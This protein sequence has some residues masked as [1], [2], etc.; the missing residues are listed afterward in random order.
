MPDRSRGSGPDGRGRDGLS[1]SV[2]FSTYPASVGVDKEPPSTTGD[3]GCGPDF[4]DTC[5]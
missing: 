1:L 4:T 2:Q 5:K 3:G